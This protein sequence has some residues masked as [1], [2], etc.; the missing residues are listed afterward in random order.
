MLV[1]DNSFLENVYCTTI[2][3]YVYNTDI[4][5]SNLIVSIGGFGTIGLALFLRFCDTSW[6][7]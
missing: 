5:L 2:K 3:H 1:Y 6:L 7:Q 4:Y